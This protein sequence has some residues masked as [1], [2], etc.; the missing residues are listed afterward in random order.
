VDENVAVLKVLSETEILE[1]TLSIDENIED[2][3]TLPLMNLKDTSS[4]LKKLIK[5]LL[6]SDI[7]VEV[8]GT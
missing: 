4:S 5:F 7:S 3:Y 8:L 1:N 2:V 6:H